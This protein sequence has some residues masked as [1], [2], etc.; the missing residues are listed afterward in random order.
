MKF[1][2]ELKKVLKDQTIET[3]AAY[4]A[5]G[6][7]CMIPE[8]KHK[9]K[10]GQAILELYPRFE[11]VVIKRSVSGKFRLPNI[12]VIAGKKST[13]TTHRENYCFFRL[14]VAKVMFSK[15]NQEEKRRIIRQVK[16]GEVIVDMFAGIGYFSLP[17]AKRT[18]AK[19]IYSIEL[20]PESFKFLEENIRINKLG[21]KVIPVKGDCRKVRVPKADR[22]LMGYLPSAK[23]FLTAALKLAKKGAVIH[24][25]TTAETEAKA[26]KDVEKLGKI[27]HI[28][29]VK[30]YS[31]HK[32]HVVVDFQLSY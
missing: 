26:K 6:K 7:I 28:Q 29:K 2:K 1:D 30:K 5:I 24:Y 20:N 12:E 3:P 15:G 11:T 31:P 10:I 17:I 25:H 22:V 8:V 23:K 32:W 13:D 14:D 21:D 19:R 9:R 16:R 27:L 18:Q 4:Q